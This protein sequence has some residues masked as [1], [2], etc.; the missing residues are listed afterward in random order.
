MRLVNLTPQHAAR[1]FQGSVLLALFSFRNG[2]V[3]RDSSL[4]AKNQA[5]GPPHAKLLELPL[6]AQ[7]ACTLLR[8]AG[9]FSLRAN[10]LCKPAHHGASAPHDL[11][12]RSRALVPKRRVK[13]AGFRE[14]ASVAL[15]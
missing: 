8:G 13:T 3:S 1:P 4:S 11:R 10:L 5:I 15:R 6:I 12:R 7:K 2:E 14:F 9:C